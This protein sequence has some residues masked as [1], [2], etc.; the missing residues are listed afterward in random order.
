MYQRWPATLKDTS[1]KLIHGMMQMNS[2][3]LMC[4]QIE[5]RVICAESGGN[6][7]KKVGSKQCLEVRKN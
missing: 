6:R 1:E 3:I 2:T 4:V 7:H 5:F